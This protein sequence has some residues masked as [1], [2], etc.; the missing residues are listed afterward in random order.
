MNNELILYRNTAKLFK[1]EFDKEL[2]NK[3][4]NL[5]IKEHGESDLLSL[6]TGYTLQ[7]AVESEIKWKEYN[8]PNYV[9][10][11]EYTDLVKKYFK[12]GF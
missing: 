8:K 3:F 4:P 5:K 2:K 6:Y 12:R 9:L 11:K 7:G 10:R 1:S